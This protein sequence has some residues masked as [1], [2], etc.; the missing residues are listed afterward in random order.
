MSRSFILKDHQERSECPDPQDPQDTPVL[1]V[2][3]GLVAFPVK[4]ALQDPRDQ[5]D[6]VGIVE[7]RD[8]WAL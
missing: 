6:V 7:R 2:N 3:P 1:V 5:E 8:P 4:Q